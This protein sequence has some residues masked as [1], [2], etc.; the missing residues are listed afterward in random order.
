[1]PRSRTH[2]SR[3]TTRH[4]RRS[5]HSRVRRSGGKTGSRNGSRRG[6]RRRNGESRRYRASPS[7]AASKEALKRLFGDD[8]DDCTKFRY[9]YPKKTDNPTETV[10]PS[11]QVIVCRDGK[12]A[13]CGHPLF[14]SKCCQVHA[15][16][17]INRNRVVQLCKQNEERDKTENRLFR[18]LQS[19]IILSFLYNDIGDAGDHATAIRMDLDKWMQS[20]TPAKTADVENVTDGVEAVTVESASSSGPSIGVRQPDLVKGGEKTDR[21]LM[22]PNPQEEEE[23]EDIDATIEALIQ[24]NLRLHK[25]PQLVDSNFFFVTIS[26][27]ITTARQTA[28]KLSFRPQFS[29]NKNEFY[30]FTHRLNIPSETRDGVWKTDSVLN[31]KTGF[32]VFVPYSRIPAEEPTQTFE[33]HRTYVS[34][35]KKKISK[36]YPQFLGGIKTPDITRLQLNNNVAEETQLATGLATLQMDEITRPPVE[37]EMILSYGGQDMI[38]SNLCLSVTLLDFNSDVVPITF[39]EVA[40]EL[41]QKISPKLSF[42]EFNTTFTPTRFHEVSNENL[43]V[44]MCNTKREDIRKAIGRVIL[45]RELSPKVEELI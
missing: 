4:S 10:S 17:I 35:P 37:N 44:Y 5:R 15:T 25:V 11:C 8:G 41:F 1:M 6:S 45:K 3:R 20:Q 14:S 18:K 16:E 28:Y 19:R 21:A 32:K 9:Y 39:G 30:F 7:I 33:L 26:R 29:G 42:K 2:G 31:M 36:K 12:D 43:S 38:E 27:V 13:P 34:R 40:M 24:E 22:M 23:E